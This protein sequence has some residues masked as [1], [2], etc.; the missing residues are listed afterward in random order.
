LPFSLST[1]PPLRFI[2]ASARAGHQH[3]LIISA[4][5][6]ALDGWATGHMIREIFASYDAM[7]AGTPLERKAPS[8]F[9][10]YLEW[11]HRLRESGKVARQNA[12]WRRRLE[13]LPMT[14]DLPAD[15]SRPSFQDPRGARQ[16]IDFGRD[17]SSAIN[18]CAK[19]LNI[20][21]TA[22]LLGALGLT[23]SRYAGMTSLL[24]GMPVAGRSAPGLDDL[25]AATI[26]L[27]PVP[28]EISEEITAADFLL[29]TQASLAQSLDNSDVPFRE[30]VSAL[31]VTGVPAMPLPLGL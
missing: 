8:Q 26:N 27:I 17:L 6:I 20:T 7:L 31:G 19:R 3:A 24:I 1:T 2:G 12:F 30:L 5:H 11:Q 21:P 4:H 23:V 18:A 16:P 15:R 10:D 25:V 29:R 28:I 9:E 14:V 22:F 13:R